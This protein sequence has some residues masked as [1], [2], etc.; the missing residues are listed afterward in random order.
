MV[1]GTAL[2]GHNYCS[3][4]ALS[5]QNPANSQQYYVFAL[6]AAENYLVGGLKYNLVDMTRQGG[7]GEVI[8]SRVQ[9]FAVQLTEKLTA[10][11]HANGRDAWILMHGWQTNTF[12]AYLLTASGL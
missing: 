1:N 7:L 3:Q 11:L 6:D 9:V 4:G 8:R 5:V 12:Y 10:V 2:G